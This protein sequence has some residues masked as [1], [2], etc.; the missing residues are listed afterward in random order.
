MDRKGKQT[1]LEER[2][3]ILNLYDRKT[4]YAEIAKI[5]RRNP[6]TVW[7]V[8]HRFKKT[9][10]L[11]NKPRKGAP[12]KLSSRDRRQLVEMVKQN[13]RTTASEIRGHLEETLGKVV[14]EETVCRVLHSAG[15]RSR[16][17]RRKPYISKINKK[18]RLEFAKEY[19]T[20]NG[21]SGIV[22][23]GRT[24]V[25]LIS[26]VATT[27]FEFVERRTQNGTPKTWKLQS[28]MVVVA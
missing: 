5:V 23:C 27:D 8:I 9:H 13:P 26:T 25:N 24:K 12:P 4:S 1:N 10:S 17:P 7:F 2:E 20:K 19:A 28:N 3:I 22:Y 14:H 15:Y 16:V 21:S 18:K 11:V 6:S